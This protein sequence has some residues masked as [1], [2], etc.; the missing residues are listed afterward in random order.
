MQLFWNCAQRIA[1]MW[2]LKYMLWTIVPVLSENKRTNTGDKYLWTV[3]RDCHLHPKITALLRIA[4]ALVMMIVSTVP[5]AEKLQRSHPTPVS[6]C[7]IDHQYDYHLLYN[8]E[9]YRS[10]NHVFHNFLSLRGRIRHLPYHPD[11][12]SGFMCTAGSRLGG[13]HEY[14][15]DNVG[16]ELDFGELDKLR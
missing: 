14:H 16:D 3:T 2:Q 12:I 11:G 1:V 13:G 4:V 5:K 6:P 15:H 10:C 9:A 7:S 8:F